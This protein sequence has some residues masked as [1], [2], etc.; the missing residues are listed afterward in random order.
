MDR[1]CLTIAGFSQPSVARGL[2]E[3]SES[4]EIWLSQRFLW[5]FPKPSYCRF[6][7]LE[8]VDKAFTDTLGKDA[9]NSSGKRV[10]TFTA[11]ELL[12]CS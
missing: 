3:Q 1:T 6:R 5:L 8:G 7:T 4:A 10:C 12:F 11:I 2:I 9:Y